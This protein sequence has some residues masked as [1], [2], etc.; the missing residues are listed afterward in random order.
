MARTIGNIFELKAQFFSE[1]TQS[2]QAYAV[3][4]V[5]MR[6][7]FPS[8]HSAMSEPRDHLLHHVENLSQ[9]LDTVST[10]DLLQTMERVTYGSLLRPVV[11]ILQGTS[12][13]VE[14][15]WGS[16]VPRVQLL[17]SIRSLVSVGSLPLNGV[18]LQ[19]P[20]RIQAYRAMPDLLP[21]ESLRYFIQEPDYSFP[22]I[23]KRLIT[24]PVK[25]DTY[26]TEP[27]SFQRVFDGLDAYPG[28]KP[29]QP[30]WSLPPHLRHSI[31]EQL[32]VSIGDYHTLVHP[33][34]NSYLSRLTN[35]YRILVDSLQVLRN[36]L[37]WM[38]TIRLTAVYP[39]MIYTY[40]V[41]WKIGLYVIYGLLERRRVE[42]DQLVKRIV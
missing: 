35:E 16:V 10:T 32:G 23:F 30:Y 25:L 1:F 15:V 17:P 22:E 12:R 42:I 39:T 27:V 19:L 11:L 33:E 29:G 8:S 20:P 24:K 38:N 6:E 31:V 26:Y 14:A 3:V 40:L 34:V 13:V 18:E 28:V 4:R 37:I 2:Q 9:Q 7:H 41:L 36:P 21:D 5:L